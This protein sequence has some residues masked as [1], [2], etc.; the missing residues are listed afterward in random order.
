MAI[1]GGDL[2]H[3]GNKILIDRAQTIGPGD[4][5]IN[6]EK[7]YEVGNY[8]SLASIPD[9]PDL[10]FSLE[11][12]DASAEF[13]AVLLN[14]AYSV[15]GG[16]ATV[17]VNGTGG[18]FTLSYGGQTTAAINYGATKADVLAALEA[19]S[20]LAPGDVSVDG[21]PGGPYTIL[22]SPAFLAANSPVGTVTADGTALTGT[23]AAATIATAEGVLMP[24][25]TALN[26]AKYLPMDIV[27]AFKPGFSAQNAYDVVGSV[28]IPHLSLET[29]SYRFGITDF[30]TQSATLRGDSLYYSPTTS[31]LETFAGTNTANQAVT[32]AYPAIVYHG[33]T[34][35]STTVAGTVTAG[36]RYA[37]SV[38]LVKAGKR[39]LPGADYEESVTAGGALTITVIKPVATT[40]Q[41][42]VMYASTQPGTY[43]QASHAPV[44]K[45]RPAAIRGRNVEVYIGGAA[46]TNRWT[47][48]QTVNVDWRVTLDRDEELGNQNYVSQTFDTPDVT[49]S[50]ELRPRDYEELYRKICQIAGVAVGE[51][52][53]PL[54]TVP[55]PL[56]IVLHSPDDGKVLKT[57]E[58][59]DARFTL[60]G[61]SGQ[62]GQNQKINVTFNFTS[63]TGAMV[64]YKGA[65]P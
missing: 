50:V 11:S 60:P 29:L 2:I 7:I 28:G 64:V 15:A 49:G 57:I 47:S 62:A 43:P 9:T 42:R 1:K 46:I 26:P 55:L 18:T 53:G 44:T 5:T 52:A 48:V 24:D 63:D 45:V 14:Q 16:T 54:T 10:S 41:I 32:V 51:V 65:K 58:I 25:G 40:E 59:A 39:L 13:E 27:S 31:W 8:Y 17:T 12:Y 61:Y 56:L 3:V 34:N 6:L 30:A 38:S 19:L 36:T 35:N 22:F 20:N 33:D 4:V 37:L 21:N 23:G